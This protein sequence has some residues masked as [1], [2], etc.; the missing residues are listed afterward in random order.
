MRIIAIAGLL[1]LLAC[2]DD[3]PTGPRPDD[4]VASVWR[5]TV[6]DGDSVPVAL[7]TGQTLV[8]GSV[9]LYATGW[10]RLE[11]EMQPPLPREFVGRYTISGESIEL[12]GGSGHGPLVGA[13]AGTD[14]SLTSGAMQ[15]TYARDP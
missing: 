10:Y 6:L 12:H 9:T 7:P 3:G 11:N 5:L 15:A 8:G 1:G 2:G 14:L 4:P 13:F